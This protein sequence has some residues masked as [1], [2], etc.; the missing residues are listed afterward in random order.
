LQSA[1]GPRGV[2]VS[3]QHTLM[4]LI[5]VHVQYIGATLTSAVISL[6][7]ATVRTKYLYL[8]PCML[9][10]RNADVILFHSSLTLIF[11]HYKYM[12]LQSQAHCSYQNA[13][14]EGV[15]KPAGPPLWSSDYSFWLQMQRS[16]VQFLTLPDFLRSSESETKSLQPR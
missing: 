15:Q 1:A 7:A 14:T 13:H 12:S 5:H 4:S 10:P 2:R 3:E 8:I 16:R 9:C 6:I 11:F